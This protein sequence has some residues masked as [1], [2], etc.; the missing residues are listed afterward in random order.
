VFV[1]RARSKLNGRNR[2]DRRDE[3]LEKLSENIEILRMENERQSMLVDSFGAEVSRLR[4]ENL[5]L[6][7]LLDEKKKEFQP[8][9][10]EQRGIPVL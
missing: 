5:E 9:T 8:L 6:R 2:V 10:W 4:V 1:S 3:E 7:S